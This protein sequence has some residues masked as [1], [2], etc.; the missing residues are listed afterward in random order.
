MN[1]TPP[2]PADHHVENGRLRC[3][4]V[5]QDDRNMAVAAHLSLL[6]GLVLGPF[7]FLVPLALWFSNRDRSP[8]R[9]DHCAE[10]LNVGITA[11][12]A[13]VALMFWW[14]IIP[15]IV[16]GAWFLVAFIAM[17]RAAVAGSHGEYFRYPMTIRL[18][19]T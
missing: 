10:A 9:A 8:Y 19:S 12:L 6:S 16:A 5:G 7:V 13:F 3:N 14:L 4:G 1:Q 2:I 11:T 15:L 18:V 17:I